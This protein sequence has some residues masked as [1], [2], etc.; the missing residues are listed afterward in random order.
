MGLTR[1]M[2]EARMRGMKLVVV[3]PVCSTAASKADEWI[4]IRPGTDAALAL[5]LMHVLVHE[6]GCYDAAYLRQYTN[7]PYLVGADGYCLRDRES[8]KPL[9]WDART[10]RA[11]A[12]DAVDPED[13]ALEG[14]YRVEGV[15][16]R[17]AFQL[18]K[19]HLRAYPPEWAAEITTVPAATLRRV[20]REFGQ[21]ACVGATVRLEGTDLPLRPAAAIWYRGISAHK[22]AML[23]GMS[24][25]QLNLLLGT[26][27]VPGGLL[28]VT[29]AGPSWGPAAGP[30]GLLVSGNPFIGRYMRATMPPQQ[31]QAPDTLE[32]VEMFPL[33]VYARSMLWL[34]VLQAEQFGLPYRAE[35]LIHCRTNMMATAGDPEIMAEALRRIPFIASFAT[36]HDETTQFADLVLPDAHALERLVPIV[37]NSY[38]HYADAPLPGEAW[39]FNC[40]QPVVQPQGQ[41]RYWIE[42]LLEVADRLG[43]LGEV[44][45]AFNAAAR[46]EGPYRLDPGQK[47]TWRE[48]GDRL[49]RS[50]CGEEH[51]LQYLL[52]HG[53]YKAG[54]RS[55]RESYPRAFHRARVPLYLEHFLGVGEEVRRFTEEHDIP[56]DTADYVPLVEWRPC[57]AYQGSPPEYDLFVVNQKLPFLTFSFTSENP[58]LIELAERNAKVFPVGINADTARRKG[59]QEGDEIVLETPGG[60]K[61]RGIARLAQGIHPECLAVPGILGRQI[62]SNDRLRGRGVHFNGLIEYTLDRLDTLSAAL[63]ACVKVKIGKAPGG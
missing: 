63:D 20:A 43:L 34:G 51:G 9:V 17:P 45:A 4:P 57:P 38:L 19:E 27:D 7:A 54:P 61:A 29:A 16:A 33:S 15:E 55:A 2:A 35:V 59:I 39:G 25:A 58:W 13:A 42:V 23:S 41:A 30:D 48:I 21:A 14:C 47:Y 60:R 31:V 12:F 24:L 36:H 10:G 5:A 11:G 56:W 40:Q 32:L 62:T 49:A 46:L 53:Y 22:H 28:N 44:Y 26:V 52:E 8:G 1:E 6:L 37:F 18:F 3:D 50:F